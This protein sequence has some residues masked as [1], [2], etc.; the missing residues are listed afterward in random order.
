M[1]A[2][3]LS[4]SEHSLLLGRTNATVGSA[5]YASDFSQ[6]ESVHPMFTTLF[7]LHFLFSVTFF[8]H[9]T[10]NAIFVTTGRLCVTGACVVGV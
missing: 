9:F 8:S 7:P 2:E 1:F 3:R 6:G 5:L 10:N 4:V